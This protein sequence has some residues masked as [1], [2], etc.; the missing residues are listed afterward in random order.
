RAPIGTRRAEMLASVAK[1]LDEFH[2]S[3]GPADGPG[4]IVEC[5]PIRAG[6]DPALMAELARLVPVQII[7]C[8][9]FWCEAAAPQ[10]P[11]AAKLAADPDGV[12]KMAALFI[13][14]IMEGM[15]DPSGEW[16]ERFTS[17]KAGIIKCATSKYMRPSE[18]RCHEAAAIAARETGCPITT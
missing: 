14:E 18:R 13:R 12:R 16:G 17:I 8:T 15:E 10:H 11:W 5:T 1:L 7:A 9:G 6:R 4:A 2:K 3:L